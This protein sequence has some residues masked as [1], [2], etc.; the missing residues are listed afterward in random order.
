MR[1]GVI[2]EV[3]QDDFEFVPVALESEFR[4]DAFGEAQRLR[5]RVGRSVMPALGFDNGQFNIELVYNPEADTVH[6]VEINPRMSSQF[7]DLFE[8]V[9]G[10][11]SA[12]EFSQA[13][14]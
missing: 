11:K 14:N 7:A 2:H 1:D 6:I 8:K 12:R 5:F 13:T 4:R 9:D 3:A 10:T